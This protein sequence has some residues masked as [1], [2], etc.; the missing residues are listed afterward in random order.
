MQVIYG[1]SALRNKPTGEKARQDV[2]SNVRSQPDPRVAY[3][4]EIAP[5]EFSCL[6]SEHQG[7]SVDLDQ[8]TPTAAERL[9][10]QLVKKF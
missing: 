4:T 6:A 1:G 9:V 10:Q 7:T 5:T 3:G 8:S 2:F